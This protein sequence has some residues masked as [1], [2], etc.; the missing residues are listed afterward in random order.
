MVKLEKTIQ[1]E[2]LKLKER[3]AQINHDAGVEITKRQY[4]RWLRM[5]R[6]LHGDQATL[7]MVCF[8][9]DDYWPKR[10]LPITADATSGPT[11]IHKLEPVIVPSMMRFVT[12]VPS[13]GLNG[14]NGFSRP[15]V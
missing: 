11:P 1:P 9:G 2:R 8:E 7:D 5:L 10:L 6:E 14:E 13:Y 12:A 15:R 4:G 3:A